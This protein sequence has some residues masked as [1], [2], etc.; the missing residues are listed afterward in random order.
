MTLRTGVHLW[1]MIFGRG[2]D[3]SEPMEKIQHLRAA[4]TGEEVFV[5][6]GKP[7]DLVRENRADDDDLV[8]V[9]Q[10]G[11]DLHRHVHLE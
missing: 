8:V 6:T 9:E 1:P 2:D 11:V 3:G 4:D 5:A 10:L 7:D